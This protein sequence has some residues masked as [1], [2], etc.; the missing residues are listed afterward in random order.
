MFKDLA[1]VFQKSFK[2]FVLVNFKTDLMV[3]DYYMSYQ[4][5]SAKEKAVFVKEL[6]SLI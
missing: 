5:K 6:N 3:K 2:L 4:I 1:E